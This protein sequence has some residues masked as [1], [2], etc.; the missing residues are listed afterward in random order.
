M[1]RPCDCHK[2]WTNYGTSG[3]KVSSLTIR[4]HHQK[5]GP[6]PSAS[7]QGSQ[8]APNESSKP[9]SEPSHSSEPPP[10]NKS[11]ETVSSVRDEILKISLSNL[12]ITPVSS[13][14][15]DTSLISKDKGVRSKGKQEYGICIQLVFVFNLIR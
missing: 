1:D 12:N 2:C 9:S 15:I 7:K 8:R 3:P 10:P 13:S 6:R 5:N 11:D 4:R 14:L